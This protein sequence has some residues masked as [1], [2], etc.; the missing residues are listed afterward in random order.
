MTIKKS[1]VTIMKP[2]SNI[3][4]IR[5]NLSGNGTPLS[6]VRKSVLNI[7]CQLLTNR[8]L[9]SR[10]RSK[11]RNGNRNI[12]PKSNIWNHS[13]TIRK[14]ASSIRFYVYTAKNWHHVPIRIHLSTY[15]KSV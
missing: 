14:S 1:A 13:L 7:R 8:K 12:K 4:R 15:R 11:N 5:I 9:A 3:I 2:S 10:I 6:T